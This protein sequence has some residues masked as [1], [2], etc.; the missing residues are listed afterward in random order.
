MAKG[1]STGAF[2]ITKHKSLVAQTLINGKL[3]YGVLAYAHDPRANT[4]LQG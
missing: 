4:Q 3:R 1:F 2:Q